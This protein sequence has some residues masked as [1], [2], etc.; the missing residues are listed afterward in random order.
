MCEK[1]CFNS[2]NAANSDFPQAKVTTGHKGC[3]LKTYASRH[4]QRLL[5]DTMNNSWRKQTDQKPWEER[6]GNE[7]F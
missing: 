2:P 5:P 6:L 4:F 7:I 3:L 1:S